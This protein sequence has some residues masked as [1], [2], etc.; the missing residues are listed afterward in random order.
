MDI[1]T[2]SE[3][4]VD[5]VIGIHPWERQV[6]QKVVLSLN[7]GVDAARAAASDHID[8]ALDYSRVADS[9]TALVTKAECHL[10][11]TLAERIAG[12]LMREHGVN[13]L[14]LDLRKPSAVANTRYVGV[15]IERGNRD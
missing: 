2:I 11:E 6:R 7:L 15:V 3:L 9:V 8:D 14:R 1:V 12:H 13:W 5:T 4:E 10:L